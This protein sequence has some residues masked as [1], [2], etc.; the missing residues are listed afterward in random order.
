MHAAALFAAILWIAGLTAV[1]LIQVIAT[2]SALTRIL[3]LNTLSTLLL[4]LLA[5]YAQMTGSSYALDAALVLAALSFVGTI[6]AA[7]SYRSGRLFE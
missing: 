1:V 7:R 3:A 6:A 2:R 4:A 5:V